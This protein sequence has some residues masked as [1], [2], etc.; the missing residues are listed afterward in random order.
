M[1]KYFLIYNISI[2]DMFNKFYLFFIITFL[3]LCISYNGQ[4]EM[5]DELGDGYVF[6]SDGEITWICGDNTYDDG[7]PGNVMDFVFDNGYIIATQEPSKSYYLYFFAEELT[8]RYKLLLYNNKVKQ[9]PDEHHK[10]FMASIWWT[11]TLLKNKIT[12]QL[13]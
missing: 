4:N 8:A 12:K 7:I 1:I 9:N 2:Q 11:E 6:S 3:F 5:P 13:F 10:R